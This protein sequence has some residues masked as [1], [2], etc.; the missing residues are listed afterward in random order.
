MTTVLLPPSSHVLYAA[1]SV[2]LWTDAGA[3][4]VGSKSFIN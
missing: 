4:E 3:K 1:F 2:N